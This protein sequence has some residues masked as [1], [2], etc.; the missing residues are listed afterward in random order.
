M[1]LYILDLATG[2][3]IA[4]F[5]EGHSFV[6]AFVDGP[7]LTFSPARVPTAIGFRASTTFRRRS[8]NMETAAGHSARRGEHLFNC[9]VCRDDEGYVMAYESSQPVMFCFR[10]APVEGSRPVDEDSGT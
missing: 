9:S 4:R 1:Y 2:Q 6:N 5:G 10:F 8:E 7:T 3:E